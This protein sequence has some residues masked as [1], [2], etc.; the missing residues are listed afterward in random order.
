MER[1]RA[2]LEAL[3]QVV[4]RKF[5]LRLK[6]GER[7][8]SNGEGIVI[9][10]PARS[11]DALGGTGQGAERLLRYQKG[12]TIH[13]SGHIVHGS[14]EV[15]FFA[16]KA[17]A[18]RPGFFRLWH[19]LEDSR[20]EN[21]L[22]TQY[23]GAEKN[24]LA[25]LAPA[26]EYCRTLAGA[27]ALSP[28]DQC[29]WGLYLLGRWGA[30]AEDLAW[31]SDGVR[32]LLLK[33][34]KQIREAAGSDDP[35]VAFRQAEALYELV[36]EWVQEQGEESALEGS[37]RMEEV[38]PEGT[39]PEEEAEHEEG[40]SEQQTQASQAA[41][42][43]EELA[44]GRPA[45]GHWAAPW[46][47]LGEM[48]KRVH[49]SALLPD[50][51]TIVIPPLGKDSEYEK[52]IRSA[53]SEIKVL[54]Y[55]LTQLIKERSYTRYGGYFRSG[56]LNTPKLW[57]QR[58][59]KYRL[60][61]R[62]VEPRKLDVAFTLLVD[63][64]GSMNREG[65]YLAAREATIFFA[66][67]LDQVGVP[68]EIIGYSTE[69]SEAAMAAALGHV[70]AFRYRH[71]RHSPLLHR[72]YKTFDEP[73]G[74]VKTRLVSICPR[75]NNWD[76]EHLL[77]AHR[78][79]LGRREKEKVIIIISD[80][81]PNGDARHLIATVEKLSSLGI[82]IVGVGVVDPFVKK[83]YPNAIVVEN[84][85]QLTEEVVMILRRELLRS[86]SGGLMGEGRA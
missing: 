20:V 76:E 79:M 42:T 61:Q 30:G 51:L 52:I 19:A 41:E 27:G 53:G 66:E 24:L 29:Q 58:L 83:I 50:E 25:T 86:W 43:L 32:R 45:L 23:P 17:E 60:F 5:D 82:K 37:S 44:Q 2:R 77:F 34:E 8:Q 33:A 1:R 22:I 85:S 67:V 78:R 39:P 21:L 4:T 80:G 48:E 68:F 11:L 9:E 7:R 18:E 75:F 36:R 84:L 14:L 56:K 35:M 31:L 10:D 81:Q 63:E 46:F 6:Y 70:P 59:Q 16:G 54:I 55:R 72:L 3:A 57:K 15:A 74:P 69:H 65:K 28:F 38:R 49:P 26:I 47:E 40:A 64:S 12:M 73:Y 62:R 71:I 13:E